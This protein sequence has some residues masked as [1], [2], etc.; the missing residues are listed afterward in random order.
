M[1]ATQPDAAIRVLV[2]DDSAFMRKAI[3]SMLL[4]DPRIM[5]V[6]TARNGDEALAQV[7][8][9]K[10]DVMTLDIEMPGMNGLEVLR[11]VMQSTPLPVIM[12]S[13]VTEEG[14]H[15]TL[16]ALDLGAVDYI[17]KHLQGS[18]MNI[19]SIQHDLV[20]KVVMAHRVGPRLARLVRSTLP[21]MISRANRPLARL[22]ATGQA[23]GMRMVAIG[24]STGG[25]KALQEIL[26]CFP[27][28]FP[29]PI[30]VVQHM[31]KFFTGPFA[32]RLDQLSQI[33][34]RE[35]QEG[36]VPLP[37]LA[38]IAPGGLHMRVVRRGALDVVVA[39]SSEPVTAHMPSVD[40]LMTSVAQAYPDRA[41]GVILTGMGHDG[42]EGMK[43]IKAA[44]GR[45][46]AQDEASCVVYGMP[47]AVVDSGLADMVVP[48]QQIAAEI[49]N[50]V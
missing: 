8:A 26:P 46:I 5:I 49:A 29:A 50:V 31:P 19:V 40:M 14:A 4:S 20:E 32:Q 41:I 15:E 43:A 13:S 11:H 12:V 6:G 2:V 9:L 36:D 7:Q 17:P 18:A 1:K 16:R 24:C 21:P 38:L 37:G 30:V 48:L 44:H 47:K 33:E 27:K 10:P 25:P 42:E 23:R 45:T 3:S 22:A 28:D 35:A 34:V 39:L